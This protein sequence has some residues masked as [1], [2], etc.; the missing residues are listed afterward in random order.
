MRRY[1]I[2]KAHE[3]DPARAVA[4]DETSRQ[5]ERYTRRHRSYDL[6]AHV[7]D[8]FVG[9]APR[10]RLFASCTGRLLEVGVGTGVN[11]RYYPSGVEAHAIDLTPAM[12][13]VAQRRA[14]ALGL[15]VAVQQM[16]VCALDY[17]DGYFDRVVASCVFCSVPDPV[18]GLREL[19]RVVRAGG[20]IRLLE[21]MR[22]DLPLLGRI[23]DG[24]DGLLY[25]WMGFHI[26][27]RTLE[28]I[29]A[30]GLRVKIDEPRLG[31]VF[32][33]LELAPEDGR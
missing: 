7:V 25:R 20:E 29:A 30:A 6:S 26:A 9:R 1:E 32:H 5:I 3:V 19:R 14:F 4:V 11:F 8:L 18:A 21:H 15:T 22:P 10:A 31:T 16:D 33:Y 23:F 27:R 13:G 28:N 24:L 2:L 12:V 17:P